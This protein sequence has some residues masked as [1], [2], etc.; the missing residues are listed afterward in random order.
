M[1][2]Q[3]AAGEQCRPS[4]LSRGHHFSFWGWA[5][6]LLVVLVCAWPNLSFAQTGGNVQVYSGPAAS[7]SSPPVERFTIAGTVLDAVSGEPIR[8]ALVQLN[9]MQR[10]TAFSD[11]QGRFQFEGVPAGG[12][13]LTAQKPGYFPEQEIAR[14]TMPVVEVGP[15]AA[16]A[17]VKL[18][19]EAVIFG[20]VTTADGTPLEHVSLTLTRLNIRDGQRHWDNQGNTNS[21]EDGHFRFPTLRPGTYYLGAS[22][23]TPPPENLLESDQPPTSGYR[24]VYY[25][26]ATELTSASPIQLA[27]GQQMEADLSLNEVPVYKVS[28]IVTGFAPNR[29]VG[30]QVLDQSGMQVPVGVDFNTENGRFDVAAL[31]AGTYVLKAFSQLEANENVR[32]E[33]RFSLAGDLRNLRLTLTPAA[34]IP[35]SVTLDSQAQ[36]NQTRRARI[37]SGPMGLPVSVRLSGSGPSATDA[38]AN[39]ERQPGQQSLI[40]RGVDP[41]RYSARIETQES[42]YVASAEYGQTNLLND[43]LVLTQGAPVQPLRIVLRNDSATL[44]G[45]VHVPDGSTSPVTVVAF[46]EGASKAQPRLGTYVPAQNNRSDPASFTLSP[47][48]PGDYTVFAFDRMDDV[49]YSNP[50]VLQNYAAKGVHVVLSPNQQAKVTLELIR[51]DEAT[52]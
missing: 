18:Y 5:A 11:G 33:L 31:A 48:A 14:G 51:T 45:T 7:V 8:K 35:V 30:L 47:L 12:V 32:A 42:W 49:E 2:K 36:T 50:D 10:R 16:P 21:D 28:G 26:G 15:N 38:F 37:G 27:A 43:D 44:T 25:A 1:P 20:K 22:P 40:F 9:G 6:T 41:G 34:T 39:V 19:P 29:S 52:K 3:H 24:G 17:V 46:P 13:S 23:F 4:R